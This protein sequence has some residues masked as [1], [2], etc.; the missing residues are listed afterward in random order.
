[1]GE[2]TREISGVGLEELKAL[3]VQALEENARKPDSLPEGARFKGYEDFTVQD[4]IIKARTACYRRE[5]WLLPSGETVVA[6]LQKLGLMSLTVLP[7]PVQIAT[8]AALWGSIAEQGFLDGAVIVSD[9]AGQFRSR[10]ARALVG[11]C[12][13]PHSQ[14]RCVL[15][16]AR[17]SEGAHPRPHLAPLQGPQGVSSGANGAP[18]P[19]T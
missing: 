3:L 2:S 1:M 12:G 19:R 18:G 13:T 8:E 11:P 9:G 15:Q 7:D 4:I 16:G 6:A 17:P 14:A 10:R 5:R